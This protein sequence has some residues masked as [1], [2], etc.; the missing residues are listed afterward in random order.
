MGPLFVTEASRDSAHNARLMKSDHFND[1]QTHTCTASV[2]SVKLGNKSTLQ[3][4]ADAKI[5]VP[6]ELPEVTQE[7]VEVP[8]S[9]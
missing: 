1:S 2:I 9:T 8:F 6:P 7:K 3:P 4:P 5:T